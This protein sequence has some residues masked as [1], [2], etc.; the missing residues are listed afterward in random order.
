[1][2]RHWLSTVPLLFG[3]A[4][5]AR[6]GQ[7]TALVGTLTQITGA[8]QL[9]GPGV[10]G[11]PLASPWQVVRAGVTVRVPEGGAAGIACS[12]RRFVRLRG[13]ATWSL[14]DK[15]CAA[16]EELT[17]AEYAVVAPHAGRFNVID[18][19]QTLEREIR[20]IDGDDPLVPRVLSPRGGLRSPRLAISWLRVRSA[21]E[22]RI[23]LNGRSVHYDAIVKSEDVSCTRS[24]E[25]LDACSLPWPADRP[26]LPPGEIFFLGIAA[27][28]GLVEPWHGTDPIELTTPTLAG[29]K[30]LDTRLQ[31]IDSFGLQS[32]VREAARA[33]LF[34][35]AGLYT[36]AAEAYRRALAAAPSPELRVT[37]AD[38]YLISGLPSLA[39]PRYREALK[40]PSP[41]IQAAAA[42][43]LGRIEYA[44]AR[45]QEA[46]RQFQRARQLY[47]DLKL[48]EEEEAARRAADRAAARAPR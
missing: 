30:A 23:D 37:L 38:I 11:D 14:T 35:E 12:T 13:P 3:L 36:D 26:D 33:G 29:A 22:Y 47:A 5:A 6:A 20:G 16:G 32:A 18:G 17:P 41:A 31:R 43:G 15:S 48:G 4:T 19:L 40:D 7:P 39:E 34:A 1:L 21:T 2:T 28:E 8:V 27:R 25:G 44:R 10:R 9:S 24:P 45:Y 46:A 42:F